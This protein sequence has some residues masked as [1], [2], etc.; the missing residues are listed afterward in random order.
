MHAVA[1]GAFFFVF[2]RYGLGQ[3]DEDSLTFAAILGLG[4]AALSWYQTAK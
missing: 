3:P 4:A 2:Q 1:A